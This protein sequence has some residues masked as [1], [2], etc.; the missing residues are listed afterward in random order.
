MAVGNTEREQQINV[1]SHETATQLDE[2]FAQP[3]VTK[4]FQLEIP[5]ECPKSGKRT[6]QMK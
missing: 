3:F 1:E 5:E 6:R 4:G 2:V